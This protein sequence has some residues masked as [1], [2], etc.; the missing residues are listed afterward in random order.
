MVTRITYDLRSAEDDLV[1]P[2]LAGVQGMNWSRSTSSTTPTNISGVVRRTTSRRSSRSATLLVNCQRAAPPNGGG[3]AKPMPRFPQD[4][5]STPPMAGRSCRSSSRSLAWAHAGPRP[6]NGGYSPASRSR[7]WPY[8]SATSTLTR[9]HQSVV[10]ETGP[11]IE[12][13][14]RMEIDLHGAQTRSAAGSSSR[15][16]RRRRPEPVSGATIEIFEKPFTSA[17][18]ETARATQATP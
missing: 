3:S 6:H 11:R 12:D 8:R 4:C 17:H 13:D 14:Q 2:A 5:A 10:E 9:R 15:T 18:A 16:G 7:C 1:R